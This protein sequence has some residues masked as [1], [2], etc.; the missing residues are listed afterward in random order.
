[1]KS[2]QEYNDL[3]IY[4]PEDAFSVPVNNIIVKD[5]IIFHPLQVPVYVK[6]FVLKD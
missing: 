3:K 1:M 5:G 6:K 4:H 2:I